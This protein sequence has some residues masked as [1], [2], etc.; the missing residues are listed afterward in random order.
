MSVC[1]LNHTQTLDDYATPETLL[2]PSASLADMEKWLDHDVSAYSED[3][4]YGYD[5][6]DDGDIHMWNLL[7]GGFDIDRDKILWNML[8]NRGLG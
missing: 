4:D 1:I 6:K 3:T 5:E 7:T 2:I 8:H